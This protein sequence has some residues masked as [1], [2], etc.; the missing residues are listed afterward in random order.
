MFCQNVTFDSAFVSL[1][2]SEKYEKSSFL[3]YV[4]QGSFLSEG[5]IWDSVSWTWMYYLLYNLNKS[6][7]FVFQQLPNL[8]NVQPRQVIFI[9]FAIRYMLNFGYGLRV[10]NIK[11]FCRVVRKKS[12]TLSQAHFPLVDFKYI[13][14]ATN[15]FTVACNYIDIF[16]VHVWNWDIFHTSLLLLK[17]LYAL[18]LKYS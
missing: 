2:A 16:P 3:V 7:S 4:D 12:C 15:A 17:Q 18:L 6:C 11:K 5:A 10:Q 8:M 14:Q 1:K 9:F 13:N